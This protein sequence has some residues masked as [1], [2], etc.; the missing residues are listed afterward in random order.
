M[1]MGFCARFGAGRQ[2]M[3]IRE[4]CPL[5]APSFLSFGSLARAAA[6]TLAQESE[7]R[8]QKEATQ[9]ERTDLCALAAP[10]LHHGGE[11]EAGPAKGPGKPIFWPWREMKIAMGV[12]FH[13]EE[14][15][16]ARRD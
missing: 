16:S 15:L 8:H 1:D 14:G 2:A 3:R 9:A 4:S 12:V 13:Q 6:A 11:K 10:F 7:K 5:G